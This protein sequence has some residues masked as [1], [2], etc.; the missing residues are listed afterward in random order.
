MNKLNLLEEVIDYIDD[1]PTIEK[2]PKR[3]LKDKGIYG[4]TS[5][6]VIEEIHTPL[7]YE[8]LTTT[9]G[10]SAF[11]NLV[12]VVKQEI[13]DRIKASHRAF[14][15]AGIYEK[16]KILIT[17][18]PLVNVFT[19]EAL[20]TYEIEWEFLIKSSR[21][22]LMLAICKGGFD[23]IVGESEFIK[24]TIKDAKKFGLIKYFPEKMKIIT[25][26]TALDLELLEEL[27]ELKGYAVHD[28]Y[29]TQEFG[30][31][32]IDGIELRDDIE[33]IS[34]ENKTSGDLIVGGLPTGDRFLIDQNG[35]ICNRNGKIITYSKKRSELEY[36]CIIKSTKL[37]NKITIARVAKSILR[38]KAKIVR[39]SK[40]IVLDAF[41]TKVSLRYYD[42]SKEIFFKKKPLLLEAL[43]EAQLVYQSQGKK[44]PVWT[45]RS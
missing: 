16:S 10:T 1:V 21:D 35:H 32:T 30:W 28:L 6:H 2:M 8:Y 25:A 45:K 22:A 43:I 7:N 5:A 31:I 36:E 12:G 44:D 13:P 26:G 40:D 39:T 38:Y 9:T 34:D 27:K 37:K 18:A 41:E 33:V 15:L 20:D 19:R 24:S 11:Q 4:P 29:G 42:D 14:E 23:A 3:T 17:Y